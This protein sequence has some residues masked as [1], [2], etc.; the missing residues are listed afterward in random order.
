MCSYSLQLTSE[1]ITCVRVSS[2]FTCFLAALFLNVFCSGFTV[3]Q[4][5]T[6]IFGDKD[7]F[8]VLDDGCFLFGVALE[9][10]FLCSS[11]CT[12]MLVTAELVN[13]NREERCVNYLGFCSTLLRKVFL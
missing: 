1:K 13:K 6:C 11:Y 4:P 5:P 12:Y 8:T 7:V 9:M 3:F 10:A 2:G